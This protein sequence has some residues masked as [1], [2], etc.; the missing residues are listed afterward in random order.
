MSQTSTAL[1]HAT[2]CDASCIKLH[3][4]LPYC[5]VLSQQCRSG[6]KHCSTGATLCNWTPAACCNRLGP[7]AGHQ[8]VVFVDDINLPKPH[9]FKAQ[10]P[11]EMLRLLLDRAGVFERWAACS[12]GCSWQSEYVCNSCMQPSWSCFNAGLHP[13]LIMNAR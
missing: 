5:D 13:S 3:V 11:L 1:G 9:Q 10:P 8:L 7:P 4:T 12:H 6:H 2:M